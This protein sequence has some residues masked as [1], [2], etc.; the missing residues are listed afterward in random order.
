MSWAFI[1]SY[2]F[3]VVNCKKVAS[4]HFLLEL[5]AQDRNPPCPLIYDMFY[6]RPQM[7]YEVT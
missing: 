6:E 3:L 4:L 5:T 2:S 7:S 1:F